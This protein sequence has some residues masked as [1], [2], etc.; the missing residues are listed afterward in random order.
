MISSAHVGILQN[1]GL[2]SLMGTMDT[3]FSSDSGSGE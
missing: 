1:L 2:L 3:A